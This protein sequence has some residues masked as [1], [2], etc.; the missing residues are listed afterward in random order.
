MSRAIPILDYSTFYSGYTPP[1]Q[2]L[3]L[4]KGYDLE[5]VIL[6]LVGI[7][8]SL[9]RNGYQYDKDGGI[10]SILKNLPVERAARLKQFIFRKPGFSLVQPAVIDRM[11][12]DLF[13]RLKDNHD[14]SANP[15]D[16]QFEQRLLDVMLSYNELHH[17]NE[18]IDTVL[19]SHEKVWTLMMMQGV[20]GVSKVDF[21]RTGPIKHFIMLD[22]LRKSLRDD[23][24]LMEKSL[25]ENVGICNIHEFM[26]NFL[27]LFSLVENSKGQENLLPVIPKMDQLNAYIGPMGLVMN[28]Q[29]AAD[30][31]FDIGMMLAKP[32]FETTKGHIV[33][34]DHRNFSFLLER[35]FMFLLYHKS[36]FAKLAKIKN[37]NGLFSHFGKLYYENFLVHKLL[38]FLQRDGVRI[39]PSDDNHLADFTMVVNETDVFVI[40][41]KSVALH[42]SVFDSQDAEAFKKHIEQSYLSG[43]GSVQLERYIS[44]IKEDKHN[45][46]AIGKLPKKLN[47][48]PIIVF[49]D[50]QAATYGVNDYVGQRANIEFAKFRPDFNR[51]MPLTMIQSDF[52]VENIELLKKDRNLFKKL[53]RE[54]HFFLKRSR[55]L[56][57]KNRTSQNYVQT[58]LSF[59]RFAVGKYGAYR[60]P[61]RDIFLSMGDVFELKGPTEDIP[62]VPG[63]FPDN[64]DTNRS[65]PDLSHL[66]I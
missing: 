56:Y 37:M 25:Q 1:E 65:F 55:V 14:T 60:V 52:F 43:A 30:E 57:G 22:F 61:Q 13:R 39:I 51:V 53:I 8:N 17:A 35:A 24:E 62:E 47:I 40:E 4:F 54:Y 44:Y 58:M 38:H 27:Y 20:S 42:Y 10:A 16:G 46:L 59:D 5:E 2:P 64:D 19:D 34:M 11:L 23:F 9:E 66:P 48:Y 33:L 12:V 18:T 36:D 45:L 32:F 15:F 21:V 41:V 49:A 3:E 6:A 26:G 31:K 29:M 28:K 63:I 50:S 7:R